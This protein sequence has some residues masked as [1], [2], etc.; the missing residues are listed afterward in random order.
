MTVIS[1]E[2]NLT[3]TKQELPLKFQRYNLETGQ[4]SLQ[5]RSTRLQEKSA[6]KVEA[7]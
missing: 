6:A 7:L 3:D 5:D 2:R 1:P 4:Q